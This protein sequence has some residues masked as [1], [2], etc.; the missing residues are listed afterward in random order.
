MQEDVR[1][2]LDPE[3]RG[4]E[5]P[6]APGEP[7]RSAQPVSDPVPGTGYERKQEHKREHDAEGNVPKEND[8]TDP[9]P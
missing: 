9:H 7:I 1:I 2:P 4:S 5:N 6:E 3:A 8:P